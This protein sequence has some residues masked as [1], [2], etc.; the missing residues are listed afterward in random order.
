[1]K[2]SEIKEF[3]EKEGHTEL[4]AGGTL[5]AVGLGTAAAG[6]AGGVCTVGVVIATTCPICL[7][8]APILILVG[9]YKKYGKTYKCELPSD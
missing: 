2:K 8:L 6:C 9:V 3:L 4:V 7:I 5:G 1:M